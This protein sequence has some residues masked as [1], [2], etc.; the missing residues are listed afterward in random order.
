MPEQTIKCPNCGYEIP[1]T[2]AFTHQIEERFRTF[3]EQ[4]SKHVLLR[5]NIAEVVEDNSAALEG[6][7]C[8]AHFRYLVGCFTLSTLPEHPESTMFPNQSCRTP[9]E[10]SISLCP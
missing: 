9:N 8:V 4:S 5:R 1:L 7:R 3:I 2:E 10:M 6:N